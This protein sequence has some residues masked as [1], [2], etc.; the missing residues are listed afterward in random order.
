[1]TGDV[2]R[3]RGDAGRALLFVC[4]L[5]PSE[6]H[7]PSNRRCNPL[8]IFLQRANAQL[9]MPGMSAVRHWTA[10]VVFAGLTSLPAFASA[11]PNCEAI[12]KGP[13][14]TDCYLA[15]SQF[16]RG[17]SDLAAGKAREQADAAWYRAITGT[18]PLKAKQHRPR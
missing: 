15:L 14:R 18:D 12:S 2:G 3:D 8:D 4:D 5:K 7:P 17:Q 16:Y 11:Q 1:L 9:D 6:L 13:K 10:C